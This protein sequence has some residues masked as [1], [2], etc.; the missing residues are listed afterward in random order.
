MSIFMR[1]V[2]GI[3]ECRCLSFELEISSTFIFS[4][5]I[6]SILLPRTTP[7]YGRLQQTAG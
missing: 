1:A 2:Y 4:T 7:G 5:T 3:N 6:L